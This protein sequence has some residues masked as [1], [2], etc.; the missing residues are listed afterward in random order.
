MDRD[1]KIFSMLETIIT[2]LGDLEARQSRLEQKMD[3]LFK[4]HQQLYDVSS[5][6]RTEVVKLSVKQDKHDFKNFRLH[7]EKRTG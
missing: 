4:G 2:K 1:E 7:A 6:I 3:V 5:D